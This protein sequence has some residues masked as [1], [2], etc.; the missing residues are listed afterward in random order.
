MTK[1]SSI[2]LT[3]TFTSTHKKKS[4]TSRKS[5]VEL[6]ND[7]QQDEMASLTD[8]FRQLGRELFGVERF[9]SHVTRDAFISEVV[10]GC[11]YTSA[12]IDVIANCMLSRP[13]LALEGGILLGAGLQSVQLVQGG[14][15]RE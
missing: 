2:E 14:T 13:T 3:G 12:D 9:G 4:S 10:R 8:A 11:K 7:D 6:L 1:H 5:G 15:L